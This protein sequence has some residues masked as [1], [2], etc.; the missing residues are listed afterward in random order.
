MGLVWC[1]VGLSLGEALPPVRE[2]AL[3]VSKL[4]P[5]RLILPETHRPILGL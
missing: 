4:K 2:E 5:L 3:Q 1:H